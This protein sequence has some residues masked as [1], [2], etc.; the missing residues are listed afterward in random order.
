MKKSKAW[1]ITILLLVV[2]IVMGILFWGKDKPADNSDLEISPT[3]MLPIPT[4]EVTATS[5]PTVEPVSTPTVT[6]TPTPLPTS[7][8]TPT[9]TVPLVEVSPTEM[10]ETVVIITHTP[11][12]TP[13]STPT[14]SPLPTPTSTPTP[15]VAEEEKPEYRFQMGDNVWF[16]YYNNNSLLVVRGTGATWDFESSNAK[17]D[18]IKENIFN[19]S[20]KEII[21]EEGITRIGDYALYGMTLAEKV[22]IPDSLKEVGKHGFD[23]VGYY[24]KSTTWINLD[25]ENLKVEENS[26]TDA[27]GLDN[28]TD[29]EQFMAT[30]TPTPTPT[31]L[32]DVNNPR[33][34]ATYQMTDTVVYEFYDTGTLRIVGTGEV[35]KADT[36]G[37]PYPVSELRSLMTHVE[38]EEGITYLGT[39]SLKTLHNLK[40]ATLPKSLTD[41]NTDGG[42]FKN[43]IDCTGYFNGKKFHYVSTQSHSLDTMFDT[44]KGERN[45]EHTIEWL[46]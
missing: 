18:A 26:F 11:T 4:V 46:E 37:F 13:T 15:V 27:K 3:E 14:P 39:C 40:T 32:P 10:P 21:I 2:V 6:P 45:K 38:V 31:P 8:S 28:I 30:P 41:V 16:E 19:D 23:G 20:A 22:T 25:I 12:P 35:V 34:L 9:P 43:G 44:L 29:I 42:S 1:M 24:K 17:W 36:W 5:T 7:T 33:L